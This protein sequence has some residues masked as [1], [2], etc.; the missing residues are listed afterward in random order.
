[1]KQNKLISIILNSGLVAFFLFGFFQCNQPPSKIET[2]PTMPTDPHSAARPQEA[3]V[4]HEN[5]NLNIDFDKKEIT[6][7]ATLSIKNPSKTKSL[8]LDTRHLTIEKV[9]LGKEGVGTEF[10]LTTDQPFLGQ[11]LEVAIG[12]EEDQTILIHYRTTEGSDALQWL[13]PE[14]TAGKKH[15]FLFTQGQAILSRTWFPCQDSPGIRFTWSADVTVPKELEVIM[16]A[17][18][19]SADSSTGKY[20]FEMAKPVPA[21]LVALAAGNLAFKAI[22]ERTGVFAEPEMLEK[23]AYEFA[24]MGKMVAAAEKLYGAYR[25]GRY[26]VLVLP[27]SFPFGGMENPCVTFATPTILAGDRSLVSL[28]AH[29]LAHSWSGNLVTNATWDDFWLNEGFTVYFERRIMES[30]EGKEYADML[31]VIGYQ[32]LKGTL[33]ELKSDSAATCLKLHLTGKDPDDGMNDI[34]YEKGYLLLCLLEKQV[35]REKW[36]AFLKKY[37][38]DHAFKSTTT[39]DFL[40][41]L[42]AQ[43]LK[44]NQISLEASG[45]KNWI[46]KPGLPTGVESPNS[47]R[48]AKAGLLAA[49]FSETSQLDHSKIQNWSS[50]EWLHFLRSLPSTLTIEQMGILDKEFGFTKSRNSEILFEWLSLS[51]HHKYLQAYDA[52]EYFLVHTGRRK[53]VLPLYKSL[54]KNPEGKDFANRVFANAKGNYHSVTRQSVEGLFKK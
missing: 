11:A 31:A 2:H 34:A 38:D 25:W 22:D 51:I 45:V 13:N 36:D 37:F 10:K 1:M 4:V 6:G 49:L 12:P 9:Y 21:Y 20:H 19:R 35:G 18:K 16:S 44:P 47:V 23:S 29:E 24:D 52:L 46:Y 14:Q 5:L 41:Y 32:D 33:E 26:D 48:F 3:V 54:V 7:I 17:E 8:F 43:L 39:E 50:H 27:P 30:L 42:E 28:I 40:V 53:F 15:P